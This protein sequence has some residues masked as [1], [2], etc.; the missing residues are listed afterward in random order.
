M[1]LMYTRGKITFYVNMLSRFMH[2]PSSHHLGGAKRILQYI[3]GTI[4]FGIY[5]HKV[6]DFNLVRYWDSDWAR[7]CYNGKSITRYVLNLGQ[8]Q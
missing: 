4:N 6:K 3:Y 2:C 1:Y 7:S 5:Y 8:E